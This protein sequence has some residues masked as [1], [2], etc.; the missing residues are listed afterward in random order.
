[1]NRSLILGLLLFLN[2]SGYTQSFSGKAS[3]DLHKKISYLD[4]TLYSAY[5][6]QDLQGFMKFLSKDLEWYKDVGGL[7]NYDTV[8][9][10]FKQIFSNPIRSERRLIRSSFQVYPIKDYG[11]MEMGSHKVTYMLNGK[12]M[13]G[14]FKFVMI[15][16]E[17]NG[18]W[19]IKRVLSYGHE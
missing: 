2:F 19:L 15:W 13:S 14:V 10:N 8:Y 1:M 6:N 9:H 18:Q 17:E 12:L 16:K 7:L 3:H 4:S 11:A 5:N